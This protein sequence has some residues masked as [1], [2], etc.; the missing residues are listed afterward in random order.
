MLHQAEI[1][2]SKDF[3]DLFMATT[4]L[5]LLSLAAWGLGYFGQPHI[6][7][8]FMAAYSVKSLIKARHISMTWMVIC[9][10]GA[11][12]YWFLRYPLFLC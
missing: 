10:A 12:W 7:A 11:N 9:L 3:T 2:A 4:P 6:L 8:R 1:A 5:G